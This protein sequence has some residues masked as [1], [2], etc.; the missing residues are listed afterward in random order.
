MR[1]HGLAIGH[2]IIGYNSL[3]KGLN[4]IDVNHVNIDHDL[5]NH[6]EVLAEPI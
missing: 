3:I 6:W 2:A 4:K 1:N 5:E